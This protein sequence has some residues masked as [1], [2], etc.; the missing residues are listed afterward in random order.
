MLCFIEIICF[1]IPEKPHKGVKIIK[2]S[3]LLLL[4]LL[5]YVGILL[6]YNSGAKIILINCWATQLILLQVYKQQRHMVV[7]M[8]ILYMYI[9]PLEF[10]LSIFSLL[11][12]NSCFC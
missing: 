6:L 5:R 4:L 7:V 9:S 3:F 10:G 12:N 2:V 8:G 1:I 11:Y